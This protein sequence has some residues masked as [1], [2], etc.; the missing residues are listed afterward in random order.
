MH[1]KG[2]YL[3]EYTAQH[4]RKDTGA[5][6]WIVEFVVFKK[7]WFFIDLILPAAT[8]T[9]SRPASNRNE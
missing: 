1:F 5:L 7:I 4:K 2:K 3:E 6:V 8:W 9:W